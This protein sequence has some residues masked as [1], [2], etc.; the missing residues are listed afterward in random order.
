[1]RIGFV[2]PPLDKVRL[3]VQNSLG[4]WTYEVGRRRV[5]ELSTWDQIANDLAAYDE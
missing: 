5:D 4:F 1:M 3:P 2:N